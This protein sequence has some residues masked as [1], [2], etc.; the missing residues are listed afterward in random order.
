MRSDRPSPPEPPSPQSRLFTEF[1][2]AEAAGEVGLEQTEEVLSALRAALRSELR[3]R[4][5]W[6]SSPRYLGIVGWQ[7]WGDG[8]PGGGPLAELVGECYTFI[9]VDRRRA[10]RAQLTVKS[11][12]DGLV[13][14]N[15]R[16]FF[17]ERQKAHDPIGFRVFEVVW[18]AVQRS[19]ADGVLTILDGDSKVRNDTVL[20]F[21]AASDPSLAP[22]ADLYAWASRV[23]DELLPRL[24]TARGERQDAVA[25]ELAERLAARRGQGPQVFRFKDL[26]DAFKD[27]VR[28][29]WAAILQAE[30]HVELEEVE[31]AA[32]QAWLPPPADSYEERESFRALVA[33]VLLALQSIEVPETTR[34]YLSTL[35]QFLRVQSEGA[36]EPEPAAAGA[37]AAAGVKRRRRPGRP[38]DRA[39]AEELL[40]PREQLPRL[41]GILGGIVER[42]RSN[43]GAAG[44]RGSLEGAL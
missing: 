22:P 42:C 40:I 5:L 25:L 8:G 30:P 44:L 14:L 29:R 1:V 9:F 12:I 17:Y 26:V 33:C 18:A 38:S 15:I 24:V 21:D 32:R 7:S 4:G 39:L 36:G 23:D 11:N 19:L 6:E 34:G 10:L 41:F 28:E 43:G 35:W 3:H 31:G 13:F 16:H 2:R 20:G 37:P 27:D